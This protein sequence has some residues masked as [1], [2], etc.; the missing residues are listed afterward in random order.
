MDHNAVLEFLDEDIDQDVYK[1]VDDLTLDEVIE[2]DIECLVEKHTF[3]PKKTQ[4]SF[5]KLSD[6]CLEKGLKVNDKKPSF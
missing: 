5:D 4:K 6:C 2:K 3:K 1:Y